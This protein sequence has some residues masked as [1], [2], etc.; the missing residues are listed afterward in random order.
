MTKH[1]IRDVVVAGNKG[2]GLSYNM[3]PAGLENGISTT[4][5]YACD[6]RLEKCHVIS[7]EADSSDYVLSFDLPG[8]SQFQMEN[9]K[10][11]DNNMLGGVRLNLNDNLYFNKTTTHYILNN[12]FT[13][14][15]KGKGMIYV[16]GEGNNLGDLVQICGNLILHNT[17]LYSENIIDTEGTYVNFNANTAYNNTGNRLL[18]VK[19]DDL[20]VEYQQCRDNLISYNLGQVNEEKY[21]IEVGANGIYFQYNVLYN[22]A[23]DFEINAIQGSGT[24][25]ATHNWWRTTSATRIEERLRDSS[26]VI[27]NPD[28]N[29]EP[30]LT[31]SPP[32]I[33]SSEYKF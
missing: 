17:P 7:N 15:Q 1:S 8:G 23:N 28:I 5:P 6:I 19:Q 12:E 32:H 3:V 24:I 20:P 26:I 11:S 21:T 4:L 2:R 22:P 13:Y 10:I 14:N 30:F 33:E 29:F 25:N 18:H 31:S 27:G 16:Q 9:C